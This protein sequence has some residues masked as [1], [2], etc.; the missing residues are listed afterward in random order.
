[1]PPTNPSPIVRY[2]WDACVF[3]DYLEKTPGRIDDIAA[4]LEEVLRNSSSVIYTSALSI[5][6]VSFLSTE[7]SSRIIEPAILTKIDRMWNAQP[8]QIVEFNPIIARLARDLIRS[9]YSN[10]YKLK[11]YDATHLATAQWLTNNRIS[12][13][14]FHTYDTYD[15]KSPAIER[16]TRLK[17]CQPKP[18]Q[19]S[20]PL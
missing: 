5:V 7:K 19:P 1:M 13:A 8:F 4:V 10:G 14:E 9:G 16:Y 6:E 3:I 12:I 18:F 15:E 20:L 17:I 11:P 2:Y